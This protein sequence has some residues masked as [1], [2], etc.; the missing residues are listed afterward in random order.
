MSKPPAQQPKWNIYESSLMLETYL[1]CK[2][3][4]SGARKP[5]LE[6]LS[7]YDMLFKNDLSKE[8]I[9]KLKSVAKELLSKIKNKTDELNNWKEKEDT[10]AQ[11]R[12]LIKKSLWS[13]LP[14]NY[15][16]DDNIF[17]NYTDKIYEYVYTRY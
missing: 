7:L 3:L 12:N 6:E 16:T 1:K 15:G 14:D 11:V 5:Y 10:K 2:D 8:D 4:N 17:N 9:K 13:D